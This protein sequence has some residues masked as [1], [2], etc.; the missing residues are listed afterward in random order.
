[1]ARIPIEDDYT[2][3]LRK[4]QRGHKITDKEL[5]ARAGITQ[6]NLAAIQTGRPLDA[7]LR[8]VAQIGRA[9]V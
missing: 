6:E 4:A 1:M 7:V 3:V 2:D 8:R 5:A 9:H